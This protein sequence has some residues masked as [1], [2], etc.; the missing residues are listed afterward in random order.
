M[1]L[2]PLLHLVITASLVLLF[3][4]AARHKFRAGARFAGTLG[5]YGLLPDSLVGAFAR[6]LPV[7]ELAVAVF[8]LLPATRPWA[9]AAAAGLLGIYG[10]AMLVNLWRGRSQIDCGCGETPQ[11][12]SGWLVARNLALL[13]AALALTLPARPLV[14]GVGSAVVLLI[15]T[16]L[17]TITYVMLGQLIQNQ[18][19]LS[20]WGRDHG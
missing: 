5:A 1:T 18:S 12:L 11:A 7:L 2:D 9:A 6:G 4:T 17:L 20:A 3:M 8:L 14:F 16:G 15:L 13:V 19:A 10:L